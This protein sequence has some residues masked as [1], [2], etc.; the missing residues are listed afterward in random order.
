MPE[1][2]SLSSMALFG[3]VTDSAWIA[4][5]ADLE[6]IEIHS[7]SP[8]VHRSVYGRE[9]LESAQ[10]GGTIYIIS[11]GQYSCGNLK[12]ALPK[13]IVEPVVP[14]IKNIPNRRR[15]GDK[16]PRIKYLSP[17]F[18]ENCEVFLNAART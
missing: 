10:G 4:E 11:I 3:R 2:A 17:A 13:K 14:Y 5:M 8:K 6:S 7:S 12:P 1:A 15:L 16:A 9:F 18:E